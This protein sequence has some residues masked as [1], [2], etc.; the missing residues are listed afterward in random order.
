MGKVTLNKQEHRPWGYY[1]VIEQKEGFIV[2]I[3]HVNKG[4]R[5]SLQSHNNRSEHWVVLSGTAKVI[6]DDKVFDLNIG[7][8]TD[9]PVKAHHSLQNPYD[10]DLEILEIQMGNILSEDDIIRYEDIYGRV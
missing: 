9:I 1:T 8:S 7:Q 10:N 5:L 3:I 6:L 2:K 4:Q